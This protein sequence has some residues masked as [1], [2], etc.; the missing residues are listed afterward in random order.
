MRR[1]RHGGVPRR[2]GSSGSGSVNLI[3]MMDILT[4]LLLFLLKSYVAG[5]E[6]MVPPTGIHLPSSSADA[7]PQTSIVVVVAIDGDEILVGNER[8]TTLSQAL[9]APGLEIAPLTAHLQTV[10][11]QEED[12][13][14]LRGAAPA[15]HRIATI[16]GDRA[17]EFRVLQK[18]MYTLGQNGYENISLAVL[19]KS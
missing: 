18:V 10:K 3:S 6:V 9:G 5:G 8:V 4:V 7:P 11:R 19:Q 12:L 17:V 1:R 2:R 13:A 15:Q 16:Q 14:R